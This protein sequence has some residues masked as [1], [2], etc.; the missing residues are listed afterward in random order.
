MLVPVAQKSLA[1]VEHRGAALE[2]TCPLNNLE[3]WV[4][5]TRGSDQSLS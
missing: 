5:W 1:R 2:V 3:S 4:L